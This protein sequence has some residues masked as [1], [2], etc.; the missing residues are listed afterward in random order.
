M[1]SS[2]VRVGIAGAGMIAEMA[3]VPA[4]RRLP[5]VQVQAICDI[6]PERAEAV[7]AKFNIPRAYPDFETMLRETPLDLVSVCTP[8]AFHAPM[9]I[10]A[11][12]AGCHVLCEK[13]MATSV[14]DAEKMIATAERTGRKLTLGLHNRFRSDVQV[15]KR[16]VDAGELGPIYYTKGS[17]WRRGGIP[18]Y[19]S[20]FTR[21]ALSGGGASY[22]I[23][24]HMLDLALYI[25]GHPEPT[26]VSGA[27]YA[28]FGPRGLGLGG[29][30][31]DIYRDGPQVF[32][33]DDLASGYIRFANGATMVLE[34]SWA[35]HLRNEERLQF[36]GREGG[37]EI[38]AD[39]FSKERPL[40]IYR[41]LH[42]EPVDVSPDIPR[43]TASPYE[44]EIEEFVRHLHD[45]VPPLVTPQQGLMATRI[46]TALH[47]S[48]QQGKEI[49]L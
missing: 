2:V 48:A 49:L 24:V 3:H 40:R 34:V 8:N 30:G 36:L 10:A 41:N 43:R 13:P 14:A 5:E 38:F 28:E 27:T 37:A 4:F 42:G 19:G 29:W 12:E 1:S 9:A 31:K 7:A 39:H 46:L 47:E 45:S 44:Q 6:K 21:R 17:W 22:D 25:M 15:L 26:R 35:G 11:M 18:G 33:V 20:W 23:G 32:D 16:M